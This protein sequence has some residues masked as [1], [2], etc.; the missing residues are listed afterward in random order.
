LPDL[1]SIRSY[2]KSD[3]D[4]KALDFLLA[5]EILGRPFLAPP[6]IPADRQKVL[7]DAF[8]ATLADPEFLKDAEKGRLEIDLVTG[9]EVED[10]VRTAAASPPEVIDRVK[11]LLGR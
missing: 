7:R 8:A 10:V 6:D 2:A 11:S 4:R 1:P 5:R 3:L 9:E